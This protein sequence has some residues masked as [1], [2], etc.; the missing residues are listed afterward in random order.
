VR[1]R[2]RWTTLPGVFASTPAGSPGQNGTARW[3]AGTRDNPPDDL[4]AGP[5][6]LQW[7][8]TTPGRENAEIVP[9]DPPVPLPA[10]ASAALGGGRTA[11]AAGAGPGQRALPQR[12]RNGGA[13]CRGRGD[14]RDLPV[15]TQTAV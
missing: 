3:R 13:A 8:F 9:V 15:R 7:H 10:T 1:A 12:C 14:P 11:R 4:T 5:A 6:G 2:G